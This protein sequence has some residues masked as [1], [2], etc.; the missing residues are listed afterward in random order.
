MKRYLCPVCDQELV[1]KMYCSGCRKRVRKPLI[2]EGVLPNEDHGNY[3][4]NHQEQHPGRACVETNEQRVCKTPQE[5]RLNERFAEA[6]AAQTG[7]TY[8]RNRTTYA[9]TTSNQSSTSTGGTVYKE[10]TPRQNSQSTAP[11]S[12]IWRNSAYSGSTASRQTTSS[13]GGTSRN[14][15]S[16]K[17]GTGCVVGCL[18]VFVLFI[19]FGIIGSVIAALEGSDSWLDV[20]IDVDGTES[21]L[22]D[23]EELDYDE[24]VAEGRC[25]SGYWH[26]HVDGDQ[27]Y[28][29]LTGYAETTM[30][31]MME[32][33]TDYMSNYVYRSEF[34]DYEYFDHYLYWDWADGYISVGCDT[35]T[36][37]IH[38]IGI[39]GD[40][41]ETV[42]QL[43]VKA[44][45]LVDAEVSE[46]IIRKGMAD[47]L[48]NGEYKIEIEGSGLWFYAEVNDSYYEIEI[49]PTTE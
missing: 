47:Y 25:C 23:W 46:D 32:D 21:V 29:D 40:G 6:R 12:Q 49:Y 15:N 19:A 5:A 8:T 11:G 36:R 9:G 41:Q 20:D 3:L 16:G 18:I 14:R 4:L 22:E 31:L 37:E 43:A 38:S 2:Y 27:L 35:V 7:T 28:E 33:E 30:G 48:D 44:A 17:K 13:S 10:Y 26:Y 24:I 39:Y 34:G 1:G 42:I 45:E